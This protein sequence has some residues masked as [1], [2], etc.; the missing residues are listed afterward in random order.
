MAM[1]DELEPT[2]AGGWRRRDVGVLAAK[3]V[4]G[5]ITYGAGPQT[6]S[7]LIRTA[8][9]PDRPPHFVRAVVPR[10]PRT[11]LR[12]VAHATDDH[13]HLESVQ[14]IQD[15]HRLGAYDYDVNARTNVLGGLHMIHNNWTWIGGLPPEALP[16]AI[17]NAYG[18]PDVDSVYDALKTPTMRRLHSK[19]KLDLKKPLPILGGTPRETMLAAVAMLQDHPERK[20]MTGVWSNSPKDVNEFAYYL[21][22]VEVGLSYRTKNIQETYKML[23]EAAACGA[24]T[25]SIH[26]DGLGNDLAE[27]KKLIEYAHQTCGLYVDTWGLDVNDPD[28][29]P[30]ENLERS[31][32]NYQF[33]ADAGTDGITVNHTREARQLSDSL[34]PFGL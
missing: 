29:T 6:A 11:V 4:G 14:H 13:P 25:T 28:L 7:H 5:I 21:P 15:A 22:D 30:Q 17:L 24:T 2:E 18:S 1:A 12:I 10:G 8:L 9:L 32:E 26:L 27:A 3:I 19:A 34:P 33:A 20:E 16:S 23:D 31:L